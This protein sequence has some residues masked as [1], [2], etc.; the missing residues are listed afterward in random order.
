MNQ[1]LLRSVK[2]M[3][4]SLPLVCLF[5]V[6]LIGVTQ[7]SQASAVQKKDPDRAILFSSFFPGGG[8]FYLGDYKTGSMY[9][10]T[11]LGLFLAGNQMKDK[12]EKEE[13]NIFYLHAL[14]F[15]ELGVFTAYRETRLKMN[16][17]GYRNPIDE[18][19][20][21]KLALA[22]FKWENLKD[23]YV[24]GFFFAGIVLNAIE[25]SL[26]KKRRNFQDINEIRVM[27][28]KYE[29]DPGFVAYE[30]LW[31][32]ISLNAAVSEECLYRGV[33]QSQLEEVMGKNKGLITSSLLFGIGHITKPTEAKYW[34]YGILSSLCGFY[35]GKLYQ[36]NNYKLSKS[37]AAHFWFDV[38][39]GTT[40]FLLDPANN[41]LGLK[42]TFHF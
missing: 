23:P 7:N 30:K 12:L 1:K 29:R 28:E 18:T 42:V 5:T 40:L 36:K 10:L 21:S 24:Y 6:R 16:N 3:A 20:V 33:I 34:A 15:H 8:H 22:P 31:I 2:L 25:A 14:K 4:A 41:P 32:P 35:L 39:A 11:E 13:Q 27:G 37:I 38:A 17:V 26:N 19:P 9:L